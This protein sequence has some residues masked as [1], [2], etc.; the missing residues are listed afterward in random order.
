VW[1]W[2]A[3]Q[4]VYFARLLFCTH[5]QIVQI[6]VHWNTG[7]LIWDFPD[8]YMR[9]LARFLHELPA[10]CPGNVIQESVI[11]DDRVGVCLF[12]ALN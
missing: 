12:G 9:D 6:P 5:L 8:M 4:K 3:A 7:S 2:N 1:E 10:S 11:G